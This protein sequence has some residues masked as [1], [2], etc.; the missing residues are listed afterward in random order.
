MVI[1][2]VQLLIQV[3]LF[4]HYPHKINKNHCIIFNDFC[5][6][7]NITGND[8]NILII[9]QNGSGISTNNSTGSSQAASSVD[10]LQVIAC[11][12]GLCL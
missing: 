7:N 2:L 4:Y 6:G 10:V 8:S 1:R 5:I 11:T 9:N 12:F 3:F